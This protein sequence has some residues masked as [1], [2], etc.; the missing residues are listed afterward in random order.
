M[1]IET[2]EQFF[3]VLP[4]YCR[5]LAL[6]VGEKTIGLAISDVMHTV[7][8]PLHTI[9]R[10]QFT[11][12]LDALLK[13]IKEREIAGLV[14]GL[15]LNMDGT[16]GKKCQSVRQFGRNILKTHTIPILFWDER[17]STEA[18]MRKLRESDISADARLEKVDA[19]AAAVILQG[20]LDAK[21]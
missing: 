14:I 6:D 8:T 5:I 9:A 1:L 4:Q 21:P 3:S 15:P 11:K 12:D 20:L 13:V 17:L 19:V 18:A 10:K 7:A 2:S 16:E